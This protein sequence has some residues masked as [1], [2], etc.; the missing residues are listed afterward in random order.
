ML[1]NPPFCSG[2]L[3]YDQSAVHQLNETFLNTKV[4][5]TKGVP[6]VCFIA[7][8]HNTKVNG[9]KVKITSC[10]GGQER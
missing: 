5:N 7:K 2:D 1:G 9:V 8:T 4:P 6:T 10:T 3:S